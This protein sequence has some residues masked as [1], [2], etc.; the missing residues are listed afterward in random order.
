MSLRR[1]DPPRRAPTEG[2]EDRVLVRALRREVRRLA[3]PAKAEPMRAYMKSSMPFLGVQTPER[4]RLAREAL[5]ERPLAEFAAWRDTVLAVWRGARYREERYL[6]I[7]LVAHPKHA[8]HCT[9]RAVPVLEE[10]IVEGAWWDFVDP[11]AVGPLGEVHRRNRA[12]ATRRL[13]AW[14]RSRN[15]WKRRA[16]ILCQLK[17]GATTDDALLH[18]AIEASLDEEDFFLRKGIG[19]ALRERA[20]TDPEGVLRYVRRQR[21]R[22]SPLSKREALKGLLREGRIDAVP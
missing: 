9:L 11:L 20:K 16:A 14:A 13:R 18:E 10:M 19:W 22:L 21:A 1:I 12:G 6:A 7:D 15:V 17:H 8:D 3:D 4:R 2:L 5:R